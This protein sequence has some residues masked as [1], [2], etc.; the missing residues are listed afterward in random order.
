MKS[1]FDASFMRDAIRN[2]LQDTD[3]A[4]AEP[5]LE[6]GFSYVP[7]S[8]ALALDAD[9]SIVSGIRGSGKSFWWTY[10][11]SPRH[12]AYLAQA[13][14]EISRN[15]ENIITH[16]FGTGPLSSFPS[17]DVINRLVEKKIEPRYIW[18]SVVG[19]N[20]SLPHPF[21]TEQKAW[22]V[23]AQWVR[24]NPELFDGAVMDKDKKLRDE[25]KKALILF[26]A[27][28]RL[29]EDWPTIRPIAK[30]LFQMALEIRSYPNIR[31]KLFVRPDMLEDQ[32][33][34][35]FP[36][37]S[38]LLSKNLDLTW[39]R[40]DLYAL[41]F[42]RLGNAAKTGNRFR[43]YCHIEFSL[44]WR[45]IE[46]SASWV[47]PQELRYDEGKQKE[48]FH[49]ITGPTMARGE[50]GHKRGIP[51]TWLVNHLMDGREQ[52]SPRSFFAALR[53]A[54]QN[55]H[56]E[57]WGYALDPRSIQEGVVKASEVRKNEVVYE[58][59]PWVSALMKPLGDRRLIIPCEVSEIIN[60]WL[61]FR[62]I[63]TLRNRARKPEEVKLPPRHLA[64]GPEGILEDLKEL[65]IIARLSDGRVQMP[66]VY[67]IA[68]GLGRK[69]GVKP[70]K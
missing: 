38:K 69:G 48:L 22:E 32:K 9:I 49:A 61:E 31:I 55:A 40:A 64:D 4:S 39:R 65:G 59:Y 2:A 15:K 21:P 11:G 54:A 10:L 19:T 5:N 36:D 17:Q 56:E 16:G 47:L 43:E 37:A 51:Y 20:L 18:R 66:D 35:S 68:F 70:L 67:R 14:P 45:P 7:H 60:I 26:D 13:F 42:Q 34:T 52:V 63:E 25:G 46:A 6:P 44:S 1:P 50:S 57:T 28:D 8:H 29:A 30:A 58:D 33:I 24:D 53:E 41:L 23:K 27:L 3:Q 12:Q 62:T